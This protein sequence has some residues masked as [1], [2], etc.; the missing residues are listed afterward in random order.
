MTCSSQVCVGHLP[1]LT[2]SETLHASKWIHIIQSILSDHSGI[3]LEKKMTE[4]SLGNLQY[5]EI[6]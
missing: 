5:L 2:F 4:R 1:K 6:K 3:K